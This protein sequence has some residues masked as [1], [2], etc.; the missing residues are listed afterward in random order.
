MQRFNAFL[1]N[2]AELA[3]LS[4][5]ARS[6]SATRNLW[7][8]VIPE[9]L[10]PYTEAGDVDHKR[11]TVYAGNAAAAAKIKLLLPSL[12]TKLQKHGLEV[13]SIR[14]RVQVQSAPSKPAKNLRKLSAGAAG[15]LGK[16]AEEI[17]NN[18]ELACALKKLASRVSAN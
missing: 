12:L 6:L 8:A 3:Q 2:N 4:D 16:L 10:K 17:D 9:A 11:L 13:T 14:V 1:R 5:K 7:D 18:P 15:R